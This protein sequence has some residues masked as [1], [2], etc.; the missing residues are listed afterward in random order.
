M[1][2][3]ELTQDLAF[4][5]LKI[6]AGFL[7]FSDIWYK[8]DLIRGCVLWYSEC[9]KILSQLFASTNESY[10][11]Y[12]EKTFWSIA[13][14]ELGQGCFQFSTSQDSTKKSL[15]KQSFEVSTMT[16]EFVSLLKRLFCRY[17]SVTPIF[18]Q[19][20]NRPQRERTWHLF[21][22]LAQLTQPNCS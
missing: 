11:S 15:A 21:S 22:C 7:H 12:T 10:N 9:S 8:C 1:I 16:L 4:H 20:V 14:S 13:L 5:I 3:E 19:C 18:H 6:N 17:L 2:A